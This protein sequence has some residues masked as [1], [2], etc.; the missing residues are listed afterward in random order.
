MHYFEPAEL[1][2]LLRHVYERNRVHHL[3]MLTTVCHGLR[4]TEALSLRGRDVTDGYVATPRGKDSIPVFQR[5][6]ASPVPYLD[7]RPLAVHAGGVGRDAYLFDM[8]RSRADE[9]IKRY[10]AGVGIH[11]KKCHWHT[12]KHTTAMLVWSQSHSLSQVSQ[13]LGHRDQKTS[14]IYLHEEDRGKGLANLTAALNALSPIE[15]Q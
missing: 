4:V 2:A 15:S 6:H 14:L 12:L 11:R 9:I 1:V 8:G 7:E 3:A 5:L 13:V 10:G